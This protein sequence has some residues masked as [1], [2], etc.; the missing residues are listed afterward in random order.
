MNS[1][2]APTVLYQEVVERLR[3]RIYNYDLKPGEWIDEQALA[4]SF[5]ISRTPL[6]EALK[7]LNSEGLVVLKPRRGCFV[8][9]I[10]EQDLDEIFPVMALLEGRCAYDAVRKAKPK[11]IKRLNEIH[12]RL[13]KYAAAGDIDRFYEQN[14]IFHEAVQKL[15]GNLWL[16][17]TVGDLRKFL[18]L[19]RGRQLKLPGRLEASLKEHRLIMA[20]FHNQNP[21]AAEKIMHDHLIAQ[22]M[23]LAIYDTEEKQR[24]K[25]SFS[26]T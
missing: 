1:R 11:D 9:E 6:R 22:R 8:S 26:G 24:G 25:S 17:K 21:S 20:A 10:T 7:V 23:A 12:S 5:G 18:K 3:Q 13:E 2:I 14:Y 16:Q 19:L 15:A 4:E